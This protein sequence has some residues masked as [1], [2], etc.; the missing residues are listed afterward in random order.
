MDK[1]IYQEST[2]KHQ[3]GSLVAEYSLNMSMVS[4]SIP[5]PKNLIKCQQQNT[6]QKQGRETKWMREQWQREEV[7]EGD[8]ERERETNHTV[9]NMDTLNIA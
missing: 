5:T 4:G 1:P 6:T 7:G 9:S 8:G 2:E 3:T